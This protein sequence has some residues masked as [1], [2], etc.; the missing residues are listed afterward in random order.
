MWRRRGWC[1][2][3]TTR[4]LGG[5]PAEHHP[6]HKP[7]L[8]P[9]D[10]RANVGGYDDYPELYTR[11]FQYASFLPIFRT[12][13]SR[14]TNEVWSYASRPSRSWK[15]ICAALAAHALHLFARYQSWLTG[16]P[17]MRALP[18]VFPNDPKV[19]DLRDE[20]MFGPALPG[21][22]GDGAGRHQPRSVSA[23]RR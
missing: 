22:S 2:G 10:A 17:Y 13:G 5:L 3:R 14:N 12:H 6:A 21:G 15:S 19:A 23:G 9:S 18:L 20:Y 11:W 7:L 4:R 16:A 8:D 1:T